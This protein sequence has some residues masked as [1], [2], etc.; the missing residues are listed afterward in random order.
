M[1]AGVSFLATL[2]L[3]SIKES[4][5]FFIFYVWQINPEA[6]HDSCSFQSITHSS[7]DTVSQRLCLVLD[8][9][10]L[11]LLPLINP[12]Q[13]I[14]SVKSPVSHHPASSDNNH[15]SSLV[16]HFG[17][18]VGQQLIQMN[19]RFPQ[20]LVK[21]FHSAIILSRRSDYTD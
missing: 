5:L 12:D 14:P 18:Q 2:A 7:E 10:K 11:D 6:G 21:T 19:N 17:S 8:Y 16:S 15:R 9:K 20:Q 1:L 4:G 3:D 13:L